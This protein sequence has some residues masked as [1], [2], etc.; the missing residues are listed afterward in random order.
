MTKLTPMMQQY[1]DC[2]RRY[3]DAVLFFR[4]GDFYEMFYEDAQVV[5]RELGLTLTARKKQD[6]GGVPMA[7]VP[8]KAHQGYVAQLIDKGFTVAIAEQLED[9]SQVK[10]MVERDVVRVVT[11]GVVLDTDNLD[12]K[13]SNYV[14]AIDS[15]GDG[16]GLET[17][18]GYPDDL[19]ALVVLVLEKC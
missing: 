3:P 5:S 14:G 6:G 16:K 7:G 2:K 17:D 10:G 8:V 9:A 15:L 12:A 19:V 11:P 13:S 4:L 18:V 1:M